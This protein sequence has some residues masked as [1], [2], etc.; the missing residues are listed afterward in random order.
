MSKFWVQRCDSSLNNDPNLTVVMKELQRH[1]PGLWELWAHSWLCAPTST[2]SLECDHG[3][4]SKA[5]A[6]PK[7]DL[8]P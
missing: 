8:Q 1:Q 7:V 6:N 2:S 3:A 4:L 5:T